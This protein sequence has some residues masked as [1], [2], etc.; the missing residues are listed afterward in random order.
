[1]YWHIVPDYVAAVSSIGCRT[2]TVKHTSPFPNTYGYVGLPYVPF[3]SWFYIILYY[4]NITKSLV[5]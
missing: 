2:R 5:M 1:M 3:Q 4:A